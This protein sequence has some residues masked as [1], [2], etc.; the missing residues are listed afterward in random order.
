MPNQTIIIDVP[1]NGE[2]NKCIN[3]AR[4]VEEKYG[5]DALFPK[6]RAQRDRM[7][8]VAAV[9]AALENARKAN[10]TSADEMSLDIS[11]NEDEKS[12]ADKKGSEADDGAPKKRKRLMKE[13][14]Y[15]KDDP[16]VD[17]TELAWE[18]QAAVVKDGF[19][20]YSGPL[21]KPGE[22]PDIERYVIPPTLHFTSY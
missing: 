2:G 10:G 21:V 8:R 7:A 11:D 22:R 3:F 18:E 9:G 13:D 16:F 6:Q 20:V 5:R 17:D 15:D 19:F 4:L 14:Y 12:N 1:L